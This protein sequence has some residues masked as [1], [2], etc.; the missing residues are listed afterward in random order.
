[1]TSSEKKVKVV[2]DWLK[3]PGGRPGYKIRPRG[4]SLLTDLLLIGGSFSLLVYK[5]QRNAQK[6][7]FVITPKSGFL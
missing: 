2:S 1:M 5:V 3:L 4:F 7:L 6:W